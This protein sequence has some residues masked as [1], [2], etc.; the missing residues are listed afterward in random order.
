[1]APMRMPLRFR[2]R[3]TTPAA[4]PRRC[5]RSASR[6]SRVLISTRTGMERLVRDFLHQTPSARV[7]LLFYAGHGM[8]VDGRN[9]L[10]PVDA[11]LTLPSDLAF[12]TL[13]VDKVLAGLDDET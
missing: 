2:I 13:E 8:Q 4:S 6:S 7:S 5:A 1:M 3:R 9:Y 12:E 10:V 11:K